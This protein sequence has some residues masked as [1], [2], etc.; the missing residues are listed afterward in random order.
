VLVDV[1]PVPGVEVA[2]EV[3]VFVLLALLVVVK[4]SSG[5]IPVTPFAVDIAWK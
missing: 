3:P 5:D 1:P 4:V 2:V